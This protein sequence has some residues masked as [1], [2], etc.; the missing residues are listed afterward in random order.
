MKSDEERI[1]QFRDYLIES[2]DSAVDQALYKL[3]A[4]DVITPQFMQQNLETFLKDYED[5]LSSYF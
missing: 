1:E 5:I 3:D 2:L 4:Y